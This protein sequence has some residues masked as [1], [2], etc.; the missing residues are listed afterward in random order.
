MSDTISWYYKDYLPEQE[1]LQQRKDVAMK[2][3][4]KEEVVELNLNKDLIL[5]LSLK[6]HEKDITLNQLFNDILSETI[7]NPQYLV[8]RD[9]IS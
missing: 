3:E 6:A 5:Q 4:D 1:R 8:E 2:Q 7:R 9:N